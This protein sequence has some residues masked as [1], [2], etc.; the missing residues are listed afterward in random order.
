MPK[1]RRYQSS[2]RRAA[3]GANSG[4]RDRTHRVRQCRRLVALAAA[5]GAG[6]AV[7]HSV[8]GA[9]PQPY[10]VDIG[11][12]GNA[13]LD[14]TLD[15]ASGLARLRE[16]VPVGPFPLITRAQQDVGRLRTV[17]HSFGYYKG[18]VD[19]RID[20]HALN[21]PRLPNYLAKATTASTVSVAVKKGPDFHVRHIAIE[22]D[23]P[24]KVR[25]QLGL[26]PGQPAVAA[27]VFAAR[28]RL[29]TALQ[30]DGY[31]LAK[32]AEPVAVEHPDANALDVTFKVTTGPRLDIGPITI[33][34]L[35]TVNESFIR[36][37]LLIQPGELYQPS[38]IE[39]A[40]RDIASL[41]I[42][43]AVTVQAGDKPGP[44][45][46]L[47]LTFRIDERP[48][49]TVGVTG[50]YST[51]LG[52]RLKLTWTHRNLFGNAERLELSGAATGLGGTATN[53][54]GYD[55]TAKLTKP[56]FLIRNQ[57]LQT[58]AEALKQSLDAY[59]QRAFT[60]GASIR[61]PLSDIWSASLG[62][63]GTQER[64]RQEGVT[65]DY[66]FAGL[67]AT[68]DLDSTGAAPLADPTHGWRA[69]LGA[70]P[71]MPFGTQSSLF[72]L[73]RASGSTYVDVGRFWSA[74]PGRSVVALRALIGSIVG[75][76]QLDVPPDQRFYG[77]GS[78]TVRGYAFQSIGPKFPDGKPAGGRSIDAG[79]IEFRQRLFG[80][81]GAVAFADV[82]Q[83]SD[84]DAPFDGTP[85]V[86]VGVGARYYT[87]IGPIRLDVALPLNKPQ[88]GD[89]FELYIGIGQAF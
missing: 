74:R 11:K 44:D 41:E 40:R 13:V 6:A 35:K 43:R 54:L 55:L 12:T 59:D 39:A 24:A 30:E 47:P 81:F 23:V 73:L 19:I 14:S 42:I 75:A 20:H 37:R 45:G 26:K 60:A 61:R 3:A 33:T 57:S 79:T 70:T 32:V 64:I 4:P 8:R 76:S 88:G 69:Q 38:K 80:D 72:G 50:A 67:P 9:D 34:G 25:A 21:D 48:E 17:L 22:G 52:S 1:M 5:L 15:D 31:A 89:N 58:G 16:K 71:T 2:D 77:G 27:D 84:S 10:K 66:R 63:S 53:A 7:P 62:L 36:K 46:R 82:G 18:D 86:G 87:A 28:Q 29:L 83:V 68:V 65:R 51:D 56:D 49:H 78:A 85:R